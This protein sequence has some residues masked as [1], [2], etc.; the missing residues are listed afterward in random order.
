MRT[1]PEQLRRQL[2]MMLVWTALFW[3]MATVIV[4]ELHGTVQ[5][6]RQDTAPA[7]LDVIKAH[8]A[9]S[10]ADRAAWLSFRSGEAEFTG[11]G[12]AFQD[13]ITNASQ[14][15]QR[16]AALSGGPQLQTASGQLVNYQAL[17]E[18]ADAAYR[19]DTVLETTS[20][21]ELGYAYLTYSSQSMRGPGGLLSSI[22]DL[23]AVD[24]RAVA[25]PLASVWAAP[26]LMLVFELAGFLVLRSILLNQR[27]LKRKFR[28]RHSP[29]LMLAVTLVCGLMAWGALV[30]LPAEG[31]FHAAGGTALPKLVGVWQNQISVVDA[32]AAKLRAQPSGGLS[33]GLPVTATQPAGGALDADLATAANTGGLPVGIPALAVMIAALTWLGIKPRLDE[34]RE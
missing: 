21:H 4:V 28:R 6:V 14:E 26:G 34:Y 10:D 22:G 23:G 20:K 9:L 27:Y 30:I 19:A 8:A 3:I 15:F 11:P 7:Y 2:A 16:L 29:P 31:S 18:Q 33:G 17:V 32:Q 24:R 1:T 12:V 5:S 13:D 25:G